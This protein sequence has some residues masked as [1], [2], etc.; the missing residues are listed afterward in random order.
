MQELLKWDLPGKKGDF[1]Y[2]DELAG[3]TGVIF[4]VDSA[5]TRT[6]PKAAELL[7]KMLSHEQCRSAKLLVVANKQV[8]RSPGCAA[9]WLPRACSSYSNHSDAPIV[10]LYR[11]RATAAGRRLPLSHSTS[12]TSALSL[13]KVAVRSL[14]VGHG[15][16]G[17]GWGALD[18]SVA[19]WIGCPEV[20]HPGLLGGPGGRNLR[21]LLMAHNCMRA[22]APCSPGLAPR[23]RV[24]RGSE[25]SGSRGGSLPQHIV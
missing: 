24:G 8:R 13:S 9:A 19:R 23:C 21:G 25:G 4:V 18:C 22:V 16:G 15:R 10:P 3:I 17:A 7:H 12:R 6:F 11:S 1:G 5:N 14:V 20:D 2:E